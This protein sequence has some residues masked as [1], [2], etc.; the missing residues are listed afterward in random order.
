MKYVLDASVAL[1]WELPESDSTKA[2]VIR[3]DFIAKVHEL[4]VPDFFPVE[5]A[6]A[7][8]R[9]ERKNIL[10][11]AEGAQALQRLLKQLPQ[12]FPSLPLLPR[13]YEIASKARIG[14]YD[15]CYLAL[16][17]QESCNLITAD[18][19]LLTLT[20]FPMTDLATF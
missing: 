7:V 11:T 6:H 4:L 15:C 1:K 19:K 18:Q 13:A 9:A 2:L 12:L 10:T 5:V 17:E 3:D 16:A 20:G 8:V 14:V